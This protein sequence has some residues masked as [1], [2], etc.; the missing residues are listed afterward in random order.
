MCGG[1]AAFRNVTAQHS[2]LIVEAHPRVATLV[3]VVAHQAHTGVTLHHLTQILYIYLRRV[4]SP[5]L[6]LCDLLW[7]VTESLSMPQ[8]VAV[9]FQVPSMW[10]GHWEIRVKPLG[11]VALWLAV[12]GH[13]GI[14]HLRIKRGTRG[15][16]RNRGG[17]GSRNRVSAGFPQECCVGRLPRAGTGRNGVGFSY[18]RSDAVGSVPRAPLS[19]SDS[20]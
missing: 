12:G 9:S 6:Q 14:S 19:S 8:D 16:G 5:A 3:P 20:E 1:G 4:L 10:P 13:W 17:A 18:R 2:H 7:P 11:P 15:A